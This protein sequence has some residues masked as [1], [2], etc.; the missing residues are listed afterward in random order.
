MI[1]ATAADSAAALARRPS[2]FAGDLRFALL[3]A[4]AIAVFP[5]VLHP[6]GGYSTLATQIAIVSIASIGFNLL[7]GYAGTLS[8]GHAMFYGGGGYVA[9]ILLLRTMPQHP[10]LWLAVLGATLATSVLALAVGALTVRLYGIYFALLTLAFGQMVYFVVEQ[11][12]DWTNGDDGLQSLPNALL[13][14]GPWSVDLTTRLPALNLGPLGDLS[15]IRLWYVFAGIALLLV[16]L[17]MRALTRSQ[18]GEVLDAI[19]ENEQRSTLIGFNAAAYRL[20]AFAISGALTGLAG[21]M[22]AIFDGSVPIDAVGI[23]RSGSFVIY[24][25]VGGV[26]TLLGPV[27]GTAAIMFLENVLSAKTPAWRL[28]EGL[29]FV[30]VIVFLPRGIFGILKQRDMNV[31]ALFARSLRPSTEEPHPLLEPAAE[32]HRAGPMTIIETFKLGKFF[33]NFGAVREVD[34]KVDPGE[35]RAVIGPNGAGKTTFFNLLAG[36]I[37]P[38][39]GTI[40]FKGRD[41]SRVSG[42]SRVHLGIAKAFQTASIY[43]DQT[44]RQNCRL[45]ALARVQGPFAL[46]VIRRSTRLDDVDALAERALR[47]LEL[48]DVADV[49]AGDLSHGDKKRLD[50]AVALATQPQMLLLDEPVAGMSKDEARK[51]EA[52]IRRL[53][54]EMTVLVI[55]HDMEM[56]MGISDSITVLH[57]GN[58]L[59]TGTPEQIRQNPRVQEAYLGGHTTA[60]L[61]PG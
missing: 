56:V 30:G 57:Q 36:T 40:N 27:A 13:P 7:L 19:R 26:Q 12:K 41:V 44:V 24:T 47:R 9:A 6:L 52:L 60:E 16:L 55:E 59:A 51:T 37:A 34:F 15:E 45:A 61:L 46:Q 31:R 11:A 17:F 54:T 22:R 35:L 50:I 5:L 8:Y 43:A 28:I 20:A 49:R 10:N 42:T 53:S 48:M 4:A 29:I 38:S 32:A 21:A 1:R 14:L 2:L 3:T 58:V 18:F 23:D 39:E 25:V 33:G